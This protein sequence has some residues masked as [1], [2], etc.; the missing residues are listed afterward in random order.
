MART[1]KVVKS[2][3]NPAREPGDSPQEARVKCVEVQVSFLLSDD[4]PRTLEE[5]QAEVQEALFNMGAKRVTPASG[6]YLVNGKVC[7]PQDY[8]EK[9]RDFK[10][11]CYPPAWA[12]GPDEKEIR[13][14]IERESKLPMMAR[15]PTRL[16]T[17]KET[18]RLH[19]LERKQKSIDNAEP[20]ERSTQD[21]LADFYEN[22][23]AGRRRAAAKKVAEDEPAFDLDDDEED[24]EIEPSFDLDDLDDEEGLDEALNETSS[25]ALTALRS[26]KKPT[27]KKL[28]A[29][30]RVVARKR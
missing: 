27:T 11:G 2:S 29:K 3:I 17:S 6:Y 13:A 16:R 23:D 7:L 4:D 19:E 18:D 10:P 9:T 14:R 30:R 8:D 22:T 5:F 12:G 15:Q 26:G 1:R 28:P 25:D 21:S 24:D 20:Q